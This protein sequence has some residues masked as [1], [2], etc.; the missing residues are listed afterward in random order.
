MI[1]ALHRR[2]S[3]HSF[4]NVDQF[5]YLTGLYELCDLLLELVSQRAIMRLGIQDASDRP[6]SLV[7]DDL[8]GFGL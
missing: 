4:E 8:G 5:R 3:V 1:D 7:R 6:I 2:Q